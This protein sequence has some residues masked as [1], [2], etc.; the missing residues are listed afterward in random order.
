MEM[1]QLIKL[2][3]KPEDVIRD[4]A[5][6][7]EFLDGLTTS[8]GDVHNIDDY[9]EWPTYVDELLEF[10]GVSVTVSEKLGR[11]LSTLL[12]AHGSLVTRKTLQDMVVRDGLQPNEA[13]VRISRLRAL[14]SERMAALQIE[15]AGTGYRL[16]IID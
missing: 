6:L 7:Q 8:V 9:P 14:F 5:L 16:K 2:A 4:A 15:S 3:G 13:L 12:D 11:T 1:T 10:R